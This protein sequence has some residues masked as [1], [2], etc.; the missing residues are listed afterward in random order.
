MSRRLDGG[1]QP[2]QA[3]R[4]RPESAGAGFAGAGADEAAEVGAGFAGA[5]AEMSRR[6][7]GGDQIAEVPAL[8]AL[9]R[10]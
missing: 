9:E 6:L 5:G 7:D 4:S 10:K 8:P 3:R 2:A 1:D